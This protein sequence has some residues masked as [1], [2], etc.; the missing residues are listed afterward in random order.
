MKS[1]KEIKKELKTIGGN[2][3]MARVI[4]FQQ[5]EPELKKFGMQISNDPRLIMY[6][7]TDKPIPFFDC[8]FQKWVEETKEW[9][10]NNS[11][12]EKIQGIFPEGTQLVNGFNKRGFFVQ[13]I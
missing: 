10:S 4:Y 8:D 9:L 3:I 6:V 12:I 5:F 11:I 13:I 2:P 1:L 7:N